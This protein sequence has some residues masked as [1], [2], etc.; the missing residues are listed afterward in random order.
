M[1]APKI[2]V[3]IDFNNLKLAELIFKKYDGRHFYN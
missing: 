3:L 2:L 1:T